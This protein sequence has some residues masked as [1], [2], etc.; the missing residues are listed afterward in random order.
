MTGRGAGFCAGFA[1]QGF[2]SGGGGRAY[3]RGIGWGRGGG[4]RGW[5]NAFYATGVPGWTRFGTPMAAY[6]RLDPA[7]ERQTLRAQAQ[8]LEADLACINDRL[9]ALEQDESRA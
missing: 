1:A 9:A 5:R 6:P 3:E 7:N 2:A 8:V 4:G